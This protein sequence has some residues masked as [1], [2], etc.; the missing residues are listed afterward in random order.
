[1]EYCKCFNQNS[2]TLVKIIQ[3]L[4][5]P[6]CCTCTEHVCMGSEA[7]TGWVVHPVGCPSCS[8]KDWS[9]LQILAGVAEEVWG[10]GCKWKL[11][12]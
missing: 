3:N 6:E 2:A 5:A 11:L 1:M 4:P 8:S 9:W 10:G 12:G 7:G